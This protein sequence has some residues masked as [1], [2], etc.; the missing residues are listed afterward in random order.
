LPAWL[1]VFAG[2][3]LLGA[4]VAVATDLGLS[5]GSSA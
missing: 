2:H 5:N 4:A 1:L 3:L